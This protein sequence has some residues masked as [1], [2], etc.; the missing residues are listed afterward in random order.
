MYST[1]QYLSNDPSHVQIHSVDL[2]IILVKKHNNIAKNRDVLST[3]FYISKTAIKIKMSDH[4]GAGSL[5]LVIDIVLNNM[6]GQN[7]YFRNIF[8]YFSK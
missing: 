4:G 1:T 6:I 7:G 3:M 5:R 8:E 2:E